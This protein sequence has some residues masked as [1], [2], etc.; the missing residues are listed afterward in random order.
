MS[1]LNWS[2]KSLERGGAF[3]GVIGRFE[4]IGEVRREGLKDCVLGEGAGGGDANNACI[5][6]S[7]PGVVGES[8]WGESGGV[9]YM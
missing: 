4:M 8:G 7:I 3:E 9:T 5:G 6:A 1:P 2:W